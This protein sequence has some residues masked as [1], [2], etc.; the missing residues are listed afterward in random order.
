MTSTIPIDQA[1]TTFCEL[2]RRLG[3]GE[4]ILITES[5]RPIAKL[6]GQASALSQPRRRG[7]AKGRLI[8]LAEDDAHLEDF[9]EYMP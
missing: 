4:E 2:V 1:A 7:S 8:I 5:D 9:K 3:P 6:I